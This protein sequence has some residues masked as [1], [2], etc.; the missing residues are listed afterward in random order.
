MS[1]VKKFKNNHPDLY[2][3]IVFNI[4][5]NVATITNFLMLWIST[6]LL[7]KKVDGYFHWWI[8]DYG[9]AQGGL[10]GFLSFLLAYI[11]AQFV[12]FFVQRKVVF[13]ATV[14]IRKVIFWYVLTVIVA[15]IISVW[16][17]PYVIKQLA[18]IMGGW[19]PTV[20]NIVNIIVQVVINY[21]MMKFVIMK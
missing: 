4:M 10:G 2:E 1:A 14:Q 8:F 12:N 3:F 5:S 18:P 20:A 9:T 19:A 15:G 6:G 7:F 11:C 21:P 16:L 13:G 17:P